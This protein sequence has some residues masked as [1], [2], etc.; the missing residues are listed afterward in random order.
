[1]ETYSLNTAV[2]HIKG[3]GPV[4][5]EYLDALEIHTVKDLLYHI[6]FRYEHFAGVTTIENAPLD[7]LVSIQA[8][9]RSITKFTSRRG[10]RITRAIIEDSSGKLPVMWFNQDY[11]ITTVKKGSEYVFTGKIKLIKG[12]K[13][14]GNPGITQVDALRQEG[15][16]I[17]IYSLSEGITQKKLHSI[18]VHVLNNLPEIQEPYSKE[19]LLQHNLPTLDAT[20]RTLHNPKDTDMLTSYTHRLAFDEVLSLLKKA[21]ERKQYQQTLKSYPLTITPKDVKT[22]EHSLPYPLT[23]SQTTCLFDLSLDLSKKYPANRLIQ[24]EVGSGKTTVA[25]FALFVAAKNGQNAV[26]VAP[27]HIV[28]HQHYLTLKKMF[29][30]S[31]IPIEKIVSKTIPTQYTKGAIYVGTHAL[32]QYTKTLHP[33]VVVIDEEHRFGVNQREVF[34]HDNKK[35][36]HLITMT[37]TPIPRT[38]ALTVLADKD[39]SYIEQIPEKKKNVTTS[40]VLETKRGAA[41]AWIDEQ[42]EK[43]NTQ[44]FV[45]CPFIEQSDKE[46][47]Q[48]IASVQEEYVSIQKMFPKRNVAFLHGNMK[49]EEKEHTFQSMKDGKIDILVSTPLIEVGVDI[50]NASIMLIEGAERFGLAQLHQ[51]R[52]RIGRRG[53]KAYCLLFASK[54]KEETKRLKILEKHDDGNALA[55]LDLHMRGSGHILGTQQH[56]WSGLRFASWFDV[57]LIE[58]CKKTVS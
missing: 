39:V 45:V 29:E 28:A 17:P 6:P 26:L 20:L 53:Q 7:T 35:K 19:F 3:V 31:T 43:N 12:K 55:E 58:E 44:V 51:L 30:S 41:C 5:Q 23:H 1:M 14:L 34:S 37:A 21:E 8:T 38:A 56:G 54:D 52:G 42:I 15:E 16:N 48:S 27:T 10:L 49:N 4:I 9:L 25:A 22:F 32:F 40:I 2:S 11:I 50:P 33:A 57:K 47:L 36:P 18:L 13:T 46:N 24:G